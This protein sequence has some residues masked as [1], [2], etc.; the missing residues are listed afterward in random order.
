[1]ANQLFY[2]GKMKSVLPAQHQDTALA[3]KVFDLVKTLQ[4]ALPEKSA[5]ITPHNQQFILDV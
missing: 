1:M 2:K 3:K 5:Q 4:P